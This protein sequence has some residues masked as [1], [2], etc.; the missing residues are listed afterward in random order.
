M[1]KPV[2]CLARNQPT[3]KDRPPNRKVLSAALAPLYWPYTGLKVLHSLYLIIR[4]PHSCYHH[5]RRPLQHSAPARL[6]LFCLGQKRTRPSV[7][8]CAGYR[9]IMSQQNYILVH[10]QLWRC[11]KIKY[12]PLSS[13]A[14]SATPLTLVF[15]VEIHAIIKS[16]ESSLGQ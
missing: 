8:K 1:E 7:Q 3:E 2:S 5:V 12:D 15:R 16:S 14:F 13:H 4:H 9:R 11:N 10:W 6:I